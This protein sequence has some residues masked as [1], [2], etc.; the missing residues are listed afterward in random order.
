MV[1][2]VLVAMQNPVPVTL[3]VNDNINLLFLLIVLFTASICFIFLGRIYLINKRKGREN[4]VAETLSSMFFYFGC[5]IVMQGLIS[6]LSL[7][8]RTYNWFFMEITLYLLVSFTLMLVFFI[9]EVFRGGVQFRRN[10]VWLGITI[11]LGAIMDVYLTKDILLGSI[12][13][14]KVVFG[15]PIVC[16]LVFSFILL[17]ASAFQTSHKMRDQN[18]KRSF[19]YIG[20]GT[21]IWFFSCI[22]IIIGAFFLIGTL[23]GTEIF[24]IASIVVYAC[25]SV[26]TFFLYLGFTLPIRGA[27]PKESPEAAPTPKD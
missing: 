1:T 5:V 18:I 23:K 2:L 9:I 7:S 13:W 6:F 21:I 3:V 4:L 26:G 22:F 10:M 16:V 15:G 12:I 27:G 24:A 8:Q 14:E 25:I 11:T 17:A 19:I 20:L